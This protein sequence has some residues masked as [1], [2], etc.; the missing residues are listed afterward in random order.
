MDKTASATRAVMLPRALSLV[1]AGCLAASVIS[2]APSLAQNSPSCRDATE[3]TPEQYGPTDISATSGNQ[4]MSVGFNRDG[5]VT[6]LKWPS[7]SYFDQVKYRTRDRSEPRMGA[8]PNEGAFLGLGFKKGTRKWGFAWL[9]DWPSS[10]R[11]SDDDADEVVTTYRNRR[12]G[13]RVVVRD[14]VVHD[15]DA[16]MRSVRVVRTARSS[17]TKARVISFANFNPVFSK[18]PGDPSEDWCTESG[19]DDGARYLP[20]RDMV[21]HSRSG[22]DESTGQPSG[23]AL[24]MGFDGRSSGFEI[25]TDV[26]QTGATTTVSAYDDSADAKLSGNEMTA[27]Q[28][29]AAIARD[30]SLRSRRSATATAYIAAGGSPSEAVSG[31]REMRDRSAAAMRRAKAAWWKRWLKPTRLPKNAPPVVVKLAKRSLIAAR[32]ATDRRGLI[33][34]SIATQPPLGVDWVRNGAYINRMLLVARHPEM[35]RKHNIRYGRLQARAGSSSTTPPGNWAENYYADGE[36]GGP[37]TH[38]IDQTGLGMWTLWDHFTA[39]RDRDYLFHAADSVVYE[40]IQR[41]AHYLTD[42]PPIG[43]NDPA[44]GLYCVANDET[45]TQ[46]RMS[47]VGAQAIWLGLGAAVN[48]AQELGTETA[49]TNAEKW[50]TRR[51]TL[52]Q[53]IRQRFL[54]EECNC[55]TTDYRIGGTTLWPV[56]L[57]PYGS[58]IADAQADVNWRHIRRAMNGSAAVGGQEARALLGNAYAWSGRAA[59]MRRVKKALRWVAKATSTRSTRLLGDDWMRYPREDSGIVTMSGQPNVW[60]HAM[61]YLAAMKA[62]GGRRW[63][64]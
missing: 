30:L 47:L 45:S 56:R 21:V 17:V 16:L 29:D 6:V 3:E 48:A 53:A 15:R 49:K 11:F 43:C 46:P 60:S 24:A 34:T 5:T 19:T 32:Q 25:G 36:P 59:K 14:V 26:Y 2:P 31:L 28:T 50:R 13:L 7:P 33:V 22:V 40:A 1:L 27:G 44:T 64:P 18:A 61:F 52:K 54:S 55:Y 4:K 41:G 39:T 35:V 37:R 9:R 42:A 38:E 23:A 51:T 63:S 20:R 8:L 57:A 10:Q 12:H 58:E 62:Y